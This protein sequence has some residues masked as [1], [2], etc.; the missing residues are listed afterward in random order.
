VTAW[1]FA[2]APSWPPTLF[3]VRTERGRSPDIVAEIADV[4]EGERLETILAPHPEISVYTEPEAAAMLAGPLAR[5]R[6]HHR[7]S[8]YEF[9]RRSGELR[10]TGKTSPLNPGEMLRD[11]E[12]KELIDHLHRTNQLTPFDQELLELR[13]LGL[14]M[15]EI[16]QVFAVNI[17]AVQNH[18]L[19]ALTA[20]GAST[21]AEA[22]ER[23]RNM[24]R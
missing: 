19:D 3:V 13:L 10:R 2:G 1:H 12:Y 17:R 4:L 5:W 24:R 16:A 18:Y 21:L 11:Q 14:S 8:R 20:L 6:E 7:V 22:G 9:C 23:L 15:R